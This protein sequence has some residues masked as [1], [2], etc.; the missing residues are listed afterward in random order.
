VTTA[1]FC[2]GCGQPCPNGI[3]AECEQKERDALVDFAPELPSIETGFRLDVLTARELCALPDPPVEAR[4]LGELVVRGY[5]T[6]IGG[7]TGAGKSTFALAVLAAII[8]GCEFLG[9]SGAG[10]CRALVLDLEQGIRS[11]KR[12][13][14]EAGLEES[15]TVDYVRVPDGLS[16]GDATEQEAVKA[17][18]ARGY[19]VVL[20]DPWYKAHLGDSNA[21]RETTDLMRLLDGWREEHG[22]ALLLPMHTRKPPPAEVGPRK[23][24][25]HDLFGSSAAVRGAEV[26]LGLQLLRP[27]YSRLYYFKCRDG[28][29]DLPVNG[30]PWGLLFDRENGFRRAPDQAADEE[31]LIERIVEFVSGNPR[32]STNAIRKAVEAGTERVTAILDGDPRF[33]AE[34]GPSRS[35]LW[36]LRGAEDNPVN[37]FT[38]EAD[39]VVLGGVEPPVGGLPPEN[40]DRPGSLDAG[41]GL[42]WR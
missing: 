18:L 24:T 13:L 4:L 14:R 12:R 8:G 30:D 37:L 3:C 33:E 27:G 17:L 20:L 6:V 10:G 22:F 39:S 42:D 28:D 5:R 38:A 32:S 40:S 36:V 15:E 11:V 7:D 29:E 21:E 25:I 26:V 34:P 16:L 1:I 41:E 31:Q 23:L 2:V 19:D 9:F 35:R